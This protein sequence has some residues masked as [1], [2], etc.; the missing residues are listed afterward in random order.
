[1]IPPAREELIAVMSCSGTYRASGR[2]YAAT[3]AKRPLR[4]LPST[5]PNHMG[6]VLASRRCDLEAARDGFPA[7][8]RDGWVIPK[9]RCKLNTVHVS[10]HLARLVGIR[11]I[12]TRNGPTL[13][14]IPA[15]T[16]RSLKA[17]L[18]D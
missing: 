11:A 6:V 8:G 10:G 16:V 13:G 1:M 2:L 4:Q 5:D 7:F 9:A 12:S 15:R 17:V 3:P 14:L 18:E